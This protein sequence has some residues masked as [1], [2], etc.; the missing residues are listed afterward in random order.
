LK[1]LES[2]TYLPKVKD[3]FD[4]KQGTRT[5]LVK[6]FLLT[7]EEW[8]ELP[9]KE[10]PYFRPAVINKSIE[11]GYLNDISYCF[12][13]YGA[14]YIEKESELSIKV[15]T[16]FRTHLLPNKEKLLGRA[17]AK[18]YRWWGLSEHRM[19]QEVRQ[20]KLISTYFGGVGSFAWD[21][22]GDYVIVQGYAWIPKNKNLTEQAVLAYLAILNSPLFLELLSAVS[23][24]LGGGQWNL[25]AQFVNQIALPD[26]MSSDIDSQIIH[27]LAEAGRHIHIGSPETDKSLLTELVD[28][29]YRLPMES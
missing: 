22:K 4:V 7:K 6:T 14:Y 27:R 13:P 5:G 15:E 28:T 12:Y 16:Y 25:S 2:P 19:W 3:L 29:I 1:R 17:R 10:K 24:N 23:N 18:S 11:H 21:N 20:S 26:L 9:K 8:S